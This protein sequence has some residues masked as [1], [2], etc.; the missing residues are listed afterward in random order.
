MRQNNEIVQFCIL[1]V[2]GK[3]QTGKVLIC[4]ESLGRKHGSDWL[5]HQL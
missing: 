4:R 2:L 5:S 3:K 1:S